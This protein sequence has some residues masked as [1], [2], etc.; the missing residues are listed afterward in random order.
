MIFR[1]GRTL[2]QPDFSEGRSTPTTVSSEGL[3]I[4]E[5]HPWPGN[6]R[7]LQNVIER[8]CTVDVTEMIGPEDLR[9]WLQNCSPEEEVWKASA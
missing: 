2:H 6:V 8:A 4:L 1:C 9:P 5:A 3:K 7:E